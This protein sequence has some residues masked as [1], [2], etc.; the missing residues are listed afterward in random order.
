MRYSLNI[1]CTKGKAFKVIDGKKVYVAR[2]TI[3]LYRAR[4]PFISSTGIE[5]DG[6]R[7]MCIDRNIATLE[8]MQTIAQDVQKLRRKRL[9][10][11]LK[12]LDLL[13][14]EAMMAVSGQTSHSKVMTTPVD[15]TDMAADDLE[16]LGHTIKSRN[17]IMG[18]ALIK[19][20]QRANKEGNGFKVARSVLRNVYADPYDDKADWI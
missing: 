2:I 3:E 9:E 19:A 8:D 11:V 6:V 12:Q 18:N 17:T 14:L 10:V 16:V 1:D 13:S 15:L 4:A 7:A 5:K 20:S